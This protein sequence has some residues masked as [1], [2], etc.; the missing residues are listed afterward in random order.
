MVGDKVEIRSILKL[1]LSCDHRIVDGALG[2]SFL[3]KIKS[4]LENPEPLLPK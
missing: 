1:T 2:A 4:I 3:Q